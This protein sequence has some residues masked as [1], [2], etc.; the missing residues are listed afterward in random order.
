MP[1][2]PEFLAPIMEMYIAR[3]WGISLGTGSITNWNQ[4]NKRKTI[5][6]LKASNEVELITKSF[7]AKEIARLVRFTGKFYKLPKELTPVLLKLFHE[8]Q[9]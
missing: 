9:M 5:N 2:K 6:G 4:A 3:Y 1:M 8:K 7:Q